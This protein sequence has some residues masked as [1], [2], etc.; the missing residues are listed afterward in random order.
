MLVCDSVIVRLFSEILVWT[1]QTLN[2]YSALVLGCA[3]VTKESVLIRVSESIGRNRYVRQQ[4]HDALPLGSCVCELVSYL[5]VAHLRTGVQLFRLLL[6]H[7][8][9]SNVFNVRMY[10]RA[11][12]NIHCSS[13]FTV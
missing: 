2:A 3:M 7:L 4:L 1:V 8:V 6:H 10:K 5:V 12:A 11:F 13:R 9:R